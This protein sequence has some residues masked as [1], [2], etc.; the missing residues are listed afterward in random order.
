MSN[1]TALFFYF[2][3]VATSALFLFLARKFRGIFWPCTI[4]AIAIPSAFFCLKYTT[5]ENADYGRYVIIS[6]TLSKMNFF[7]YLNFEGAYKLETSFWLLSKISWELTSSPFLMF[8]IYYILTLIFFVSGIFSTKKLSPFRSA[9]VY[10][11][12][13]A[14]I[15]PLGISGV[16]SLLSISILFFATICLLDNREKHFIFLAILAALF[17]N[18]SII[19]AALIYVVSL[20]FRKEQTSWRK[21]ILL[22]VIPFV[23]LYFI[24]SSITYGDLL[25]FISWIPILNKYQSYQSVLQLSEPILS[26]H[27]IV[28]YNLLKS[29]IM[30]IL[31]IYSICIYVITKQEH[32]ITVRASKLL[33]LSY[34]GIVLGSITFVSRIASFLMPLLIMA[35]YDLVPESKRASI[36][37][38][39]MILICIIGFFIIFVFTADHT[40]FFP[41]HFIWE[42]GL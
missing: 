30:V 22:I 10:V 6:E 14:T 38:T 3:L 21:T 26:I 25:S 18:S 33:L 32:I 35:I 17:H 39:P 8:S 24:L 36:Y 23:T 31:L 11:F 9:I 37:L 34:L 28:I 29:V 20:F 15:I 16:R 40:G 5:L 12:L 2:T 41:L 13:L 4:L 1:L 42:G 19:V 7:E 27:S